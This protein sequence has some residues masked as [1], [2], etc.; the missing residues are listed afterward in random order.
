MP[1]KEENVLETTA[2][3]ASTDLLG[4]ARRWIEMLRDAMRLT[5][6]IFEAD[7]HNLEE[8]LG[9]SAQEK[10]RSRSILYHAILLTM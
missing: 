7:F 10:N 2:E 4:E 1:E 9:A 3:A 8:L 6:Y 5:C